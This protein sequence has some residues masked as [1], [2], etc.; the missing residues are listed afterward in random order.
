LNSFLV[1]SSVMFAC[2]SAV[3]HGSPPDA[4]LIADTYAT[5]GTR[6]ELADGRALNLRCSGEGEPVVVLEA[7]GNAESSTWHRVQPR[8]AQIHG[9]VPTI[10]PVTGSAMRDPFRVTLMRT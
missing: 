4:G 5:P 1:A 10:G 8:L 9:S 3:A 6:V 7:G 2:V